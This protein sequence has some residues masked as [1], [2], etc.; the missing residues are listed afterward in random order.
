MPETL[1]RAIAA[2][3]P[4]PGTARTWWLGQN[5]FAVRGP[6]GAALLVD[7]FVS[8]SI[9]AGLRPYT[10]ERLVPAPLDL[11]AEARLSPE[12]VLLTH[13]HADHCD[14]VYLTRLAALSDCLF[15]GPPAV[16]ERLRAWDIPG[17]RIRTIE[18]GD[19][20]AA[21]AAEIEATR[22][23]HVPGAVG[24]VVHLTAGPTLYFAGD[25]GLFLGMRAIGE[26][27]IDA[28]FLPINGQYDNLGIDGAAL[29]AAWLHAP[30]VVPTHYGMFADNTERP[31]RLAHR[32]AEAGL[33][34][35]VAILAHAEML[36]IDARA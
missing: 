24:Y 10:H 18:P 21:D 36:T 27:G 12:A 17:E 13:E 32:V 19:L 16:A 31:E 25:T 4:D 14:N 28:A 2:A 22:A 34:T 1:D 11:G 26:R 3:R 30:I 9:L 33:P 6:E 5:G 7:P 8:D 29:A 35:R 20:V 23:V 15:V